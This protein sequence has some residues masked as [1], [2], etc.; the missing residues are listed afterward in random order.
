MELY[1]FKSTNSEY[2]EEQ[3]SKWANH[4]EEII[5]SEQWKSKAR[6]IE[7]LEKKMGNIG[8][9]ENYSFPRRAHELEGLKSEEFVGIK[10]VHF[11]LY[12]EARKI[13]IRLETYNTDCFKKIDADIDE[14][15]SLSN[16]VP[17]EIASPDIDWVYICC[18]V[19]TIFC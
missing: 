8:L 17:F 13:V 11:K 14:K 3:L 19:C 2:V 4:C 9:P 1:K 5:K 16:I 6:I 12:C 15:L 7:D 18:Y 10:Q